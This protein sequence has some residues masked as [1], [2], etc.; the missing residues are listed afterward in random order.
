[1]RENQGPA[2]HTL[3]FDSC[4]ISPLAVFGGGGI[5]LHGS[6]IA[7]GYILVDSRNLAGVRVG[8]G[9]RVQRPGQLL[10]VLVVEQAAFAG[11]P[12]L[13]PIRTHGGSSW[14]SAVR[15]FAVLRWS[16]YWW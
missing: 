2:K 14:P 13:K 3:P 15:L 4:K 11:R 5:E 10:N 7:G 1:M 6:F 8:F 16:N 9:G 12:R